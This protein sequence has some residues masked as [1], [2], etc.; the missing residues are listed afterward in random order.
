MILKKN[1]KSDPLCEEDVDDVATKIRKLTHIRLDRE[2]ISKIDNLDSLGNV[3]NLYLQG[4]CITKIENLEFLAPTLRFLTLAEN[5]ITKVEGISMMKKLGLLDLADNKIINLDVNEIPKSVVF[6]VFA[7][8]KCTKDE[9]YRKNLI[10]SLENLKSI[11]GRI[12][13]EDE[14]GTEKAEEEADDS[15]E[16]FDLEDYNL[17]SNFDLKQMASDLLDR[18]CVRLDELVEDH[19]AKI[20][21]LEA[22]MKKSHAM[23]EDGK[24]T[25]VQMSEEL[26]KL[27]DKMNDVLEE[28]IQAESEGQKSLNDLDIADRPPMMPFEEPLKVKPKLAELTAPNKLKKKKLF[29]TSATTTSASAVGER[30]KPSRPDS[31]S[32]RSRPKSTDSVVRIPGSRPIRMP[33]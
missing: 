24:T 6:V 3:T 16:E 33:K 23:N 11:D 17:P 7:G 1:L 26:Q 30:Q 27:Q 4:N 31:S 32:Q 10:S 22:M 28:L 21:E 8:N 25:E 19:R 29:S 2:R 13:R 5:Q 15:D 12:L 20:D 18:S 14:D 9:D